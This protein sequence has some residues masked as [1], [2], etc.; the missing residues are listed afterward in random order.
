MITFLY[1]RKKYLLMVTLALI[2]LV[3][4]LGITTPVSASGTPL[5][6]DLNPETRISPA[7]LIQLWS[8]DG[9]TLFWTAANQHGGVR[10]Y[11]VTPGTYDVKFIQGPNTY[12]REDVD[13]SGN[14][15]LNDVSADLTVNLNGN[16]PASVAVQLLVNNGDPIWTS[17]NQQ[18]GERHYR[19]LK[20]EYDLK[21]VQGSEFLTVDVDCSGGDCEATGILADMSVD[22]SG[23]WMS[24]VAVQLLI[25]EGAPIWTVANQ[26]GDVRHY[27]VLRKAFDLK[28]V[29]GSDTFLMDMDCSGGSCVA[30]NI[31]AA[32]T[33]DLS[34]T[35]LASISV[36]LLVEGGSPIWTAAN[37][38]GGV[39]Q[40]NVFRNNYDL[41][42]VQ[43]SQVFPIDLNCTGGSCT[44]S[45]F[46]ADLTVDLSGSWLASI[47]V[48]LLVDGGSPIWTAANQHGDERHYN[49][50]K[51]TYDLKLV[52]GAEIFPV[53]IDCT[54]GSCTAGDVAAALT[55]DLSGSWLASVSVQLRVAGGDPLW[56]A[57]NQHGG[58][59]V[60]NVLPDTYDVKL[61]QGSLVFDVAGLDCDDD[62][63]DAGDVS[64]NL[65][66]NLS[67][68]WL[69]SV[70]VQLLVNDGGPIWTASNQHGGLRSYNVLPA[71]YDLKLVQGAKTL[72]I[73][74]LNCTG[75]TCNAGD[76]VANLAIEL[77]GT[78]PASIAAAL[79]INDATPNS[80]G[81]LIWSASNQH[82]ALRNYNV[83]KNF[84]D[85]RLS[86][87][88]NAYI[89][90]AV[91]CTGET[92]TLDKSGL[93]VDFPGI[94]SVHVYLYHSDN[95][96]GTVSG[97]VIASQLYKDNQAIFTNLT[98][99]KYDVR[100]VKGA[101]TLIVDNVI[102]LGNFANAG[103]LISTLTVNFPGIN[104]VHTYVKVDDGTVGTAVGGDVE[105]SLY[106][107][108]NTTI[109]V[110]KG[111]YDVRITKGASI[112]LR[113]A[114]NCTTD[115]VVTDIVST[116]TV[117]FPGINTVHT[118][119]KVDDGTA[120]TAVG[121]DV[122]S[123]LYK[124]DSTF[125]VVL[126]G[127]YDVRITKGAQAYL[128]DAVGLHDRLSHHGHRLYTD[129]QL[130]GLQRSYLRQSG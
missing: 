83:L 97:A 47:S 9:T 102:V 37:Q 4:S 60:Y 101:K 121:G 58:L 129:R 10:N 130:P 49:V 13:C 25:D 2:M 15:T 54:N 90:D 91:D 117:N 7:F 31:A 66:V 88:A 98:N 21:L 123:S 43:G 12:V 57:A 1:S 122:D 39:R 8:S 27:T 20:N 5:T 115:C 64:S 48:Q 62:S 127:M 52:Q 46:A 74:N 89:W 22:L 126:K 19:V 109:V 120:G 55:V 53:D 108:D 93:T 26:H 80:A 77:S 119:V 34:G 73:A 78:W 68:S 99:G 3:G 6:V 94:S 79:H 96:A 85:V 41:K 44:A 81:A 84:Y 125:I 114:V 65:T 111:M 128:K 51:T 28:L 30:D 36:Q 23:T 118:Y 103:T 104:T 45:N 17:A 92:C 69:A 40:Y 50:F 38:H 71:T 61:V 35:W 59:R 72:D 32:L 42:L 86:I 110:L 18:G 33:V 106:K 63:C 87:G 82:G 75:A 76:F 113:D 14:C 100:L 116:L 56:T 67:G 107:T 11:A 70:S 24:S 112:Y 95:G 29:Q 124:T 16:W 105:Q